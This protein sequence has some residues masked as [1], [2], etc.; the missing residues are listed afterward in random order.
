MLSYET[1]VELAIVVSIGLFIIYMFIF[2][3]LVPVRKYA[4]CLRGFFNMKVEVTNDDD[5]SLEGEGGG[6]ESE[7][8]GEGPT[9]SPSRSTY[10]H[11]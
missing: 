2:T 11:L 9:S 10:N 5:E 1:Y 3:F 8:E 7:G 4:D 6:C